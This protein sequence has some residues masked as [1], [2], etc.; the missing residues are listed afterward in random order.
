M[1]DEYQ[2]KT[3]S[4][5]L[6]L[7]PS[8]RARCAVDLVAFANFADEMQPLIAQGVMDPIDEMIW[9]DDARIGEVS[10]LHFIDRQT[11]EDIGSIEFP[12]RG[13]AKQ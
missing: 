6:A 9:V 11:G 13:E 10:A 3:I 12:A 7:S 5:F 8:Q 4:D 1:S 2:I